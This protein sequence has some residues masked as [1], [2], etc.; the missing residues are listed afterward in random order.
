MKSA[1]SLAVLSLGEIL[2][3]NF[4]VGRLGAENQM[5][6]RSSKSGQQAVEVEDCLSDS[7]F[8]RRE[9]AYKAPKEKTVV[10]ELSI[11]ATHA[12][13]HGSIWEIDRGA[14]LIGQI[15]FSFT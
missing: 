14:F 5:V 10:T 9:T 11:S 15:G 12:K 8:L 6:A 13:K 3:V 4:L 1:F 7:N 2:L